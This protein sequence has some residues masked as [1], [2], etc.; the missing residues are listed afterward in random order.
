MV[1]EIVI[2]LLEN[3]GKLREFNYSRLVGTLCKGF[4]EIRT[5]SP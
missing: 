5:E 1:R 4:P 3:H 2:P